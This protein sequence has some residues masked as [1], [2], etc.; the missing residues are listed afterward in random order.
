MHAL[1]PKQGEAIHCHLYGAVYIELRSRLSDNLSCD[2]SCSSSVV[3][4]E[5]TE[6]NYSSDEAS[7]RLGK[8]T[9]AFRTN[10]DRILSNLAKV[11]E[12]QDYRC[13]FNM[14]KLDMIARDGPYIP[15][16]ERLNRDKGYCAVGLVVAICQVLN[17]GGV[18]NWNRKLTLR[19]L[20]V[21][22][23][24]YP[25]DKR[26]SYKKVSHSHLLYIFLQV[27]DSQSPTDY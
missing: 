27:P 12:N 16:M 22:P 11:I 19:M 23:V 15:S 10:R 13:C 17:I 24:N 18:F 8:T 20:F 5:E 3:S 4:T 1:L 14:I 26:G 6:S 2:S 9:K 21:Q 7:F 25:W